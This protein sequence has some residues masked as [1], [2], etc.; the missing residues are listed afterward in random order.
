MTRKYVFTYCSKCK[1]EIWHREFRRYGS[2]IK[3][4]GKKGAKSLRRIVTW[5]LSC[6]NRIIDNKRKNTKKKQRFV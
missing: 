6:G 1:E 2:S 3:G 4:K 5:C